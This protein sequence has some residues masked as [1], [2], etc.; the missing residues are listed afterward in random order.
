M[1][2]DLPGAANLLG[3]GSFGHLV[4]NTPDVLTDARER[5]DDELNAVLDQFESRLQHWIEA[6]RSTK[7]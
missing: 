6:G 5:A 4:C 7:R 2:A 3:K 1:D